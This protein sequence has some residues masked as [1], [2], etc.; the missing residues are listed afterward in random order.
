MAGRVAWSPPADGAPRA[1]RSRAMVARVPAGTCT[2]SVQ[3]LGY[4]LVTFGSVGM[5][6]A[7]GPM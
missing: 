6:Y 4:W 3:L 1:G 7:F 2:R 5:Q